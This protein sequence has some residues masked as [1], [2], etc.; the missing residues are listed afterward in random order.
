MILLTGANGK[1]GKE[2][3]KWLEVYTPSHLSMDIE[4]DITPLPKVD[5][6][7]HAAAYTNVERG[8]GESGSVL[9]TN[10]LGTYNLITAYPNIPF[11]Y[12]SSEYA[13]QP[14]NVYAKSKRMAELIVEQLCPKYLIIRTLFKPRP[15]P[16]E[17]AFTDQFTRGDYVDVIGK[18]VAMEIAKWDYENKIVHIG[19][20]RK[21]MFELAKQTKPDVKPNSVLDMKVRLP[22]DY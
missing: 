15:Y 9:K 20:G 12:I 2:L 16:Y 1:L 7:I 14:V 19:T 10:V 18:L 13:A 3:T 4:K 21:T 6:I 17:Y 5:L 11:V 22:N 8:E